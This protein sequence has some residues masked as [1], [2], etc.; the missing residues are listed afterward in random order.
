MILPGKLMT[1]SDADVQMLAREPLIVVDSTPRKDCISV[2]SRLNTLVA[3]T[4]RTNPIKDIRMGIATL[5][6]CKY[7][8]ENPFSLFS[9]WRSGK[10]LGSLGA[11]GALGMSSNNFPSIFLQ[12]ISIYDFTSVFTVDLARIF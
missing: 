3:T 1:N 11:L 8:A 9:P 2:T 7:S 10:S 5:G 12:N 4:I 6:S